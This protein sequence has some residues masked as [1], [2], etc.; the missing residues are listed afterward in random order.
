MCL[1]DDPR[2]NR[3][4]L[5]RRR[6][7]CG[8]RL[9]SELCGVLPRVSGWWLLG[10][11]RGF[12]HLTSWRGRAGRALPPSSFW[13]RFIL[14]SWSSS[15]TVRCRETA[16]SALVWV[17]A[18]AGTGP[19]A[20]AGPV[21]VRIKVVPAIQLEQPIE[22]ELV[23][24][25]SSESQPPLED[26]HP[27]PVPTELNTFRVEGQVFDYTV[28][29]QGWWAPWRRLS[30]APDGEVLVVYPTGTVTARVAAAAGAPTKASVRFVEATGSAAEHPVPASEEP[31]EVLAE[32]VRCQVPAAELDL[33]LLLGDVSVGRLAA[34]A[35]EGGQIL[36]LGT[37]SAGP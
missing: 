18:L 19:A 33:E 36:D 25:I 37:L 30:G 29:G 28:R 14:N 35:L 4:L 9:G 15:S 11:Q 8:D 13:G 16:A 17:L 1:R 32:L 27:V 12:L 22:L 10:D 31:C 20:I 24:R 21:P 6:M 34:V 23:T 26:R 2:S 5:P 7:P 3:R